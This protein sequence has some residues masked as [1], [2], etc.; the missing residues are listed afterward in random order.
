MKQMQ[1]AQKKLQAQQK[2]LL[3]QQRDMM[4]IPDPSVHLLVKANPVVYHVKYSD[5]TTVGK[6]S[7]LNCQERLS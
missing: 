2:Q 7:R 6:E 1:T 4:G 3:A 5:I